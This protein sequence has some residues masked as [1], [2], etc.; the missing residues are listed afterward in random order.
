MKNNSHYT[1]CTTDLMMGLLFIFIILLVDFMIKLKEEGPGVVIRKSFEERKIL[2]ERLS[3]QMKKEGIQ[4]EVDQKNGVLKLKNFYYFK[5]GNY[6]LNEKG[7]KSFKKIR[8]IFSELICYS[9]LKNKETKKRLNLIC[10]N[11]KT[12]Q[13]CQ[14]RL[15]RWQTQ[16]QKKCDKKNKYGLLDTVLIEGHADSTPIGGSIRLDEFIDSNLELATH[17][18]L[19][20]FKFLLN[21]QEQT[22][23]VSESGNY[24]YALINR[25][26]KPLF[27]VSS[28][29]NLRRNTSNRQ[30]SSQSQKKDRRIDFRFIMSRPEE[31]KNHLKQS[32]KKLI[33]E[34]T[35][36][37]P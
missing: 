33:L 26:N 17:R 3:Q 18:S 35:E 12:R 2:L 22:R 1:L 9:D 24:L 25:N 11:S 31:L 15:S 10:E 6:R 36:I 23:E 7:K 8:N 29:G 20:V 32:D 5:K 14:N 27:G 21:Y 30:P 16:W 37:E 28:F 19:S 4:V 13:H 34:Q